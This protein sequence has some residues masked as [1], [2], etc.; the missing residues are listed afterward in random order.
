MSWGSVPTF[1]VEEEL[2]LVDANTGIPTMQNEA[3][4]E[5]ARQLGL[6]L[7]LEL[8]PCQIETSTEILDTS[9][10]LAQSLTTSRST[11]AAAA[12][13][14]G[15]AVLAAGIP[16]LLPEQGPITDT[17]RY[18]HIAAEYGIIASEQGVCGAHVH[19]AIDDRESAVEISNHMRPW[20]PVLLA[21]TANSALYDG[22][23]T[24]YA[25]W[26]SVLWSRW[27]SAG[28]PPFFES[29]DHYDSL[30]RQLF[31]VGAILD[32]KMV[33]WDIRPSMNFPTL[34]VR[35]SDVP[36]TTSDTVLLAVLVRALVMT[37]SN[38]MHQGTLAP[39]VSDH[40]L[41]WA[42]WRAARDGLSSS[43]IDPDSGCLGAAASALASLVDYV[44]AALAFTG[45]RDLVECEIRRNILHGNGAQRQRDAVEAS[46]TIADAIAEMAE[47]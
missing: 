30:V 15:A 20:L 32:D 12:G 14:A 28:P 5:H 44:S 31:D 33:Y 39:R 21:L 17:K 27:P 6:V 29:V 1:G 46:G 9:E 10:Q 35:I 45:E 3:V 41:R 42:Y 7:Q 19:T 37:A 8:T 4:A 22:R 18:R 40:A 38:A 43:L 11:A 36:A 26:R 23:D 2:L 16:P 24:G 34:E 13:R 47:R 25:S